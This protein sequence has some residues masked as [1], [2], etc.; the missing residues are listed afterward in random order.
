MELKEN[1]SALIIETSEDGQVT[2]DVAST[3]IEGLS[4]AICQAIAVKLMQDE[5]FQEEI[6][7]MIDEE[8]KDY[9]N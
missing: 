1:Q 7:E 3:K 9:N 8:Q 6:M 5:S 4:S 2:V